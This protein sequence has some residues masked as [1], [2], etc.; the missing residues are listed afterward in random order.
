M[1]EANVVRQSTR[2]SEMLE[3]KALFVFFTSRQACIE[4]LTGVTTIVGQVLGQVGPV[5]QSVSYGRFDKGEEFLERQR[6]RRVA[7]GGSLPPVEVRK[8]LEAQ[9]VESQYGFAPL[10]P[11]KACCGGLLAVKHGPVTAKT[12]AAFLEHA[13]KH[14]VST[15]LAG[16]VP[17]EQMGAWDVVLVLVLVPGEHRSADYE[18]VQGGRGEHEAGAPVSKDG[19]LV[20]PNGRAKV[21]G[22]HGVKPRQKTVHVVPVDVG[23]ELYE[24][25]PVRLGPQVPCELHHGEKLV[26]VQPP[27]FARLPLHFLVVG[28]LMTRVVQFKIGVV[29]AVLGTEVCKG[30]VDFQAVV[31][32]PSV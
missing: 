2:V 26:L 20:R 15:T 11:A 8:V 18:L 27:T 28:K 14:L 9:M 29:V 1:P 23:V 21:I 6:L 30:I 3:L 24:D 13:R 17:A 12:H 7:P 16:H 31:L 4:R 5:V 10:F 25:E 22:R 32:G 19:F